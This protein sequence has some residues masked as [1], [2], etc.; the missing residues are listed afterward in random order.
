MGYVFMILKKKTKW[1]SFFFFFIELSLFRHCYR[2]FKVNRKKPYVKPS[3]E[4]FMKPL[5]E[6]KLLR[7][8]L[9]FSADIPIFTIH[10]FIAEWQTNFAHLLVITLKMGLVTVFTN[11]AIS[12]HNYRI[13]P[14]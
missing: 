6:M 10:S 13:Y 8:E 2:K 4:T 14:E 11:P 7:K 1:L 9:D 3:E 12:Q 5:H